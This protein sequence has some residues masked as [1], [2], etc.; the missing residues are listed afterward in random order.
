MSI[1]N[2][3]I[4][5]IKTLD[6]ARF[7]IEG[8][9]CDPKSL[10]IMAPKAVFRVIRFE[11]I[12][13]QDAIIIKQDMLSLGGEVAISKDAFNLKEKADILIM[14]TLK[15][16]NELVLKLNRHYLRIREVSKELS[17]ILNKLN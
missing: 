14:G 8:I 1:H 15:Q 9:G 2:P 11:N 16:L 5:K 3:K 13:N 10:D 17:N 7:E 4:I 6:D 12:V